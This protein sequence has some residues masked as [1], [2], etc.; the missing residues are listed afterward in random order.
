MALATEQPALLAEPAALRARIQAWRS[1]GE[2]VALV[3]TMGCLHA[4]HLELVRVAARRARHVVVSIFVNPL[5]FAAGED[6]ERYPRTLQADLDALAATDCDLVFA[7]P[8]AALYPHGREGLTEVHVPELSTR[9][10]GAH[11]PGH[12]EG[13]TTVVNLLFNLVQPDLAV[14][15]AKD[16]QQLE[17]I[18]RM[19][20]DLKMPVE[21]VAAPIVRDADGLAMS[22]RNQYLS[23]AERRQAPAIHAQLQAA[24]AAIR[25]DFSSA[26]SA[27]EAARKT[28]QDQGLEVQYF[29]LRD[30]C[31]SAPTEQGPWVLLCAAMLGRTRLI[32]NLAFG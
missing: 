24:A 28:L 2:P 22:S 23:A 26:E 20:S 4:G 10:C 12:F 9:H 13:V 1:A 7:P 15:G 18:R 32:D 16:Y 27:C 8:E 5:Q 30:A 3:P 17:V 29:E 14:F 6:L 21:L 31:L 25:D 19:V 11:R